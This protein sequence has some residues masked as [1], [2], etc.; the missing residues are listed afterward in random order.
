[1]AILKLDLTVWIAFL[2]L[3]LC[4]AY[5]FDGPLRSTPAV[6]FSAS[7]ACSPSPAAWGTRGNMG[8]ATVSVTS[9]LTPQRVERAYEHAE[10]DFLVNKL[11]DAEKELNAALAI[12]P[13]SA[14]AWCLMGTLREQQLQLDDA[15]AAYS[16]ALLIDSHLLPAYLGLARIAFRGR[17]WQEVVQLTD[18]VVSLNLLSPRV[19]YLYNA[20]ANFNLANFAAAEISARRFQAL[21]PEHERP[22]VYLLLGDILASE[23]DYAGAVEQEKAFLRIVPNDYDARGIKEQVNVWEGLLNRGKASLVARDNK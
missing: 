15:V 5:G 11:D 9:L 3:P 6:P 1:M 22:Q 20:A 12:Y 13:N 21:D 19:A 10:K 18:R 4:P 17:R 8:D 7:E 2:A 23:G 16:R 14:V